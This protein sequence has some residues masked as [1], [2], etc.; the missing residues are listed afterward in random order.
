M[1]EIVEK[2]QVITAKG[3]SRRLLRE[4]S[5]AWD[6]LNRQGRSLTWFANTK[7]EEFYRLF[8]R[9]MLPKQVVMDAN[10][11]ADT[12]GLSSSMARLLQSLYNSGVEAGK[13][14]AE[15][16]KPAID[17]TPVT[18]PQ[19]GNELPGVERPKLPKAKRGPKPKAKKTGKKGW[20]G[21]Y[22]LSRGTRYMFPVVFYRHTNGLT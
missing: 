13:A 8:V 6:D 19:A 17:V 20:G 1:T 5:E 11:T 9:G 12:A 7:P 15:D 10:V 21:G 4:I 16:V 14:Q 2:S 22:P 18:I 3:V